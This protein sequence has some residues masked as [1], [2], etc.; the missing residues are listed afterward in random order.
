[1]APG[2]TQRFSDAPTL[3]KRKDEKLSHNNKPYCMILHAKGEGR[4]W[5]SVSVAAVYECSDVKGSRY[6]IF[7]A[8]IIKSAVCSQKGNDFLYLAFTD[9]PRN[10]YDGRQGGRFWTLIL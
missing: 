3:G 1:M 4:E 7:V 2:W 5:G 9:S 10:T 6:C 8:G